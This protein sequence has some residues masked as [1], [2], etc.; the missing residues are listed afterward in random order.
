MP[1]LYG[2]RANP[3]CMNPH[4]YFAIHEAAERFSVDMIKLQVRHGASANVRTADGDVIGDLLPL[5]VAVENTCMHKYPENNL[6]PTRYHRDYTYKLIHLLCLP[7]MVCST[8]SLHKV[9]NTTYAARQIK[10]KILY[11]VI[12]LVFSCVA[13]CSYFK[14]REM[15]NS[16]CQDFVLLGYWF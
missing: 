7:E 8:P 11:W 4:G 6:S 16:I 9:D 1:E 15:V 14:L 12:C 3:N 13:A 2:M 10:I 5:H